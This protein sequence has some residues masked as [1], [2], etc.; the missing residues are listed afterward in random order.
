MV[1][2]HCITYNH[3]PYIRDCLDGFVMQKTNFRFEAI[4]HDDA[5]TDGTAD[6]IREYASKYPEIIKPIFETENQYSKRDGSLT[7]IMNAACKGKYVAVCEGDD[8]WINPYKLQKQVDFLEAN[9][10]IVAVVTNCSV[11]D[12]NGQLLQAVRKMPVVPGN[13]EREYDLHDFFKGE[14][15]YPTLTAVYRRSVYEKV[16]PMIEKLRNSFLGDWILWVALHTQGNFYYLN[17][18]TAAYRI[19]PSSV[20]HTYN[21]VARWKEDFKIRKNCIDVL[22]PEYHK[23]LM[24]NCTTY[25]KLGVAYKKTGDYPKSAMYLIKAFFAHPIKFIGLLK[26]K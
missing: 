9:E 4:V 19:N 15:Q 16:I 3:E 1:S 20:T 24:N 23:Y 22:P 14:H 7:R 18:V 11:V 25:F 2:I 8:Y 26:G 12:N 6:I 10:N 5:S 21:A 13:V 17:E